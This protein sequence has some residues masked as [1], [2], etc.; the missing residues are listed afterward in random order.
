MFYEIVESYIAIMLSKEDFKLT[1][2]YEFYIHFMDYTIAGKFTPM[3]EVREKLLWGK[4]IDLESNFLA[5]WK[6]LSLM[7]YFYSCICFSK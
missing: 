3:K 4:K 1:L 7:E 6:C 2:S 5:N